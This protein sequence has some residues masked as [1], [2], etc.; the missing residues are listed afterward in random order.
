MCFAIVCF[1]FPWRSNRGFIELATARAL[2]EWQGASRKK[3]K[4]EY[5]Q[6]VVSEIIIGNL[7][8][9]HKRDSTLRRKVR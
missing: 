7:L 2:Q 9:L 4:K 1:L 6:E 8:G 3:K 5:F